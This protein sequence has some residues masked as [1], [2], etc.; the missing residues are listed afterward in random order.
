MFGTM[1]CLVCKYLLFYFHRKLF[2]TCLHVAISS[3][4]QLTS[5]YS[6]FDQF[7]IPSREKQLHGEDIVLSLISGHSVGKSGVPN[8]Q[9][10]L[11]RILWK[12]I[13]YSNR[14]SE[15]WYIARGNM[16]TYNAAELQLILTQN[17]N[18]LL[19]LVQT[20]S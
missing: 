10:I 1:M 12:Q 19:S 14:Q 17:L 9:G 20:S 15:Y 4:S 13:H 2:I 8:H 18:V 6:L 11:V 3:Q 16:V 5:S 7:A